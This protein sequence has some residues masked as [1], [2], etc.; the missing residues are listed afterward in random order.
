MHF[1]T[2]QAAVA[3]PFPF[4][5]LGVRAAPAEEETGQAARPKP[6]FLEIRLGDL[7]AG[8]MAKPEDV[9]VELL[10]NGHRAFSSPGG[11]PALL[12]HRDHVSFKGDKVVLPFFPE[13]FADGRTVPR[14]HLS[15][16]CA[17]AKEAL[18]PMSFIDVLK[19][20]ERAVQKHIPE[21]SILHASLALDDLSFDQSTALRPLALSEIR[22]A[23]HASFLSHLK[24]TALPSHLASLEVAVCLRDDFPR[25]DEQQAGRVYIGDVGTLL[26]EEVL[27]YPRS[28]AEFRFSHAVGSDAL[29][30][31]SPEPPPVESISRLGRAAGWPRRYATAPAGLSELLT[32]VKAPWTRAGRFS[33]LARSWS[34]LGSQSLAETMQGMLAQPRPSRACRQAAFGNLSA[35]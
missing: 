27:E 32:Q 5:S 19:L 24:D 25:I 6:Y 23:P 21:E 33:G 9:R 26:L 35:L 31:H 3:S 20:S 29:S 7:N 15:V 16:K 4:G 34:S 10:L 14:V 2:I 28:Q 1:Q 22:Q 12:E 13:T 18:Q 11:E 17:G 30:F 8:I